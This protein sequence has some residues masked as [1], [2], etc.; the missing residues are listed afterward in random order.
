MSIGAGGASHGSLPSQG[1]DEISALIDA[2]DVGVKVGSTAASPVKR[3]RAA[4][5][6]EQATRQ[7]IA[8]AEGLIE[9]GRASVLRDSE[10]APHDRG[11]Q[12]PADNVR[13]GPRTGSSTCSQRFVARHFPCH[14]EGSADLTATGG[15]R[16]GGFGQPA[17]KQYSSAAPAGTTGRR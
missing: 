4:T 2:A 10:R 17:A 5:S 6:R 7:L 9:Q 12:L 15:K 3:T 14:L 16:Q 11:W 8:A 1:G 13:T